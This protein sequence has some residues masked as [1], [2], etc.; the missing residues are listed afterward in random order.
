M[1]N[2][3]RFLEVQNIHKEFGNVL[4]LNNVSISASKGEVLAI[5]GDNGAGKSTLVKILSGALTPDKGKIVV[6]NR[7]FSSLTPKTALKA[8]ISTVYQDLALANSRDVA[9]NIFLGRELTKRGFLD[10]KKMHIEAEKLIDGLEID[11]P[12]VRVPVAVLSGGQRQGVAVARSVYQKGSFFIFDE[13]TAAMGLVETNA[14]LKLIKKLANQGYG[15][16]IISHNMAQVFE[17]SNRICVMRH[18][19]IAGL[20]KTKDTT[21][22]EIVSMITGAGEIL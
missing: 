8:G 14:V 15:I 20:K 9:A 3:K 1:S 17:I 18:G 4:A 2:D 21:T 11:I 6:G 5:V 7:K 12:D 19:K 10:N 22:E 16:I 13:P